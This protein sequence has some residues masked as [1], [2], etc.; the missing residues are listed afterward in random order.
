[1]ASSLRGS[2]A[3]V[4]VIDFG[5]ARAT[6][7][8]LAVTTMRT[9]VGQLVGTLQYMSPEQTEADP[10]TIDTR[11]DVY[12]LGVVLY[13]LL[14]GR[15]PYDVNGATIIAACRMICDSAPGRP[16]AINRK[17]RGDLELIVLKALE[18][19][20]Q[21]RYQSAAELAADIRRYLS[22]EPIAARPATAWTRML[23]WASKHSVAAT[24]MLSSLVAVLIVG[25]TMLS[26]WFYNFEP[27]K[28]EL[29]E[30][31]SVAPLV[32]RSGQVL[33]EWT[34]EIPGAIRFAE[35]VNRPEHFG[36][37]RL[38]IIGYSALDTGP[39]AKCLCAYEVDGDRD[40]PVWHTK[41]ENEEVLKE[42]VDNRK[43]DGAHF[44]LQL[45]KV[46]DI[47]PGDEHPG[48]E[49]VV[50]F[51]NHFSHRIIR[52]YDLESELLYE[53]WHDGAVNAPHWMEDAGLLV[54]TGDE[55]WREW[56]RSGN[57]ITG[58]PAPLVA[59]A[60]RPT[61][62]SINRED[63]LNSDESR[64][65]MQ[66]G[67]APSGLVWYKWLYQQDGIPV[68]QA[69][70]GL[71]VGRPWL[72]DPARFASLSL[73]IEDP[74][75]GVNWTIDESGDEESGTRI[76]GEFYKLARTTGDTPLPD[77][78]AFELRDDPPPLTT[79]N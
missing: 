77:P 60:L 35:L 57:S 55:Q 73:T 22:G 29:G 1:M 23:K 74:I 72:R 48:D 5:V 21:Q 3:E 7:S 41:V 15:R 61:P 62:G 27:Y 76:I 51:A 54:F 63:F 58:K 12:S 24:T 11:S 2:V 17:L 68:R 44:N 32:A 26:T 45:V 38:A 36:G 9:D 18:K 31:K 49:I 39:F 33:Y 71:S 70:S 6:D 25:G 53:A 43:S 50:T 16:S 14:C 75:Y 19:K 42:L 56:D 34:T 37:G 59:F 79:E 47:F 64:G 4:K 52:I 46:D 40:W 8:D 78:D 66:N 10:H 30:G 65:G 67:T 69:A 20:R 28:I 13:E